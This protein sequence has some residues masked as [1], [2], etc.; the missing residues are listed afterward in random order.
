MKWIFWSITSMAIL[1]NR[2]LR[3]TSPGK[4]NLT[5]NIIGH[6]PDNYHQ[7]ETLMQTID[8]Q[9]ELLFDLSP[10]ESFDV[11]ITPVEFDGARANVPANRDN[12]IAKAVI[13]FHEHYATEDGY[14][15]KV[16]LRKSIPVAGGM[17]G[18]SGNAAAALMAMNT[19][20]DKPLSNDELIGLSRELG[21]DVAFFLN[22]GTQIGRHKGDELSPLKIDK[23]LHF[24]IVSPISLSL[25]TPKIYADYDRYMDRN[26]AQIMRPDLKACIDAL[27]NGDLSEASKHFGNVFEPVVFSQVQELQFLKEELNRLGGFCAHMTGSGP[28]FYVLAPSQ[29]NAEEI[30]KKI[31]QRQTQRVATGW[32]NHPDLSVRCWVAHSIPYGVRIESK[33]SE[34]EDSL[35]VKF[36]N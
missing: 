8:L 30:Q 25:Q 22:G 20:F 9:D 16:A 13:L 7:V 6:L 34:R 14:K 26:S 5:F 28:T 31:E 35:D 27:E 12:L 18:G 32:K 33:S 21:A 11:E 2:A 17:G 36:V 10:A 4:L 24:V 3:A 15:V 1:K 29:N 19:F 23:I